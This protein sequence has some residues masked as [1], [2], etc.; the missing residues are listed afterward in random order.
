M[1]RLL[2]TLIA[3][4]FLSSLAIAQIRPYDKRGLNV[5]ENPKVDTSKYNGIKLKVGGAFTQSWQSLQ[6]TNTAAPKIVSGVD[7]NKLVALSPG[8]NTAN[9]NLYLDTQLE[10]GVYLNLT[11]Y[12]SSRHHNET[13]VKG[14][15]IQFDKLPFLHSAFFD[16]LMKYATL[17]VGHME[18]NYGDAH[19]RRSD[20]GNSIYNPFIENYIM[21]G[22]ATEIGAEVD[23]QH[24]GFIGVLGITNGEI[25]GDVA[26][27]APVTGG[28]D[29]KHH[30]AFL[31]KIG[32]DKQLSETVRLR[33]TGSGYYTAGSI[34]NTLYGGDRGGSHYFSVIEN[35]ISTT[36]AFSG[37]FNPGFT[38][39]IGSLMGNVFLKAGGFEWFSTIETTSGRARTET[40]DRKANQ[41]AT[42]AVYRFGGS[43]K[44]WL[45]ARYNTVKSE[46]VGAPDAKLDRVAI[47]GG[48]YVTKNIMAKAEYVNQNYNDFA[49]SDIRN[50]AKFHGIV[51]E[52]VVG[53]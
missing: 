8:F 51:I 15:F 28:S 19:F 16:N 1:K 37:R 43:E 33:I 2:F 20:N 12:L 22:F 23:V 9:A 52:A 38:D 27:A 21:D 35:A 10:D 31:G 4:F 17:K 25:K 36:N 3:A 5:F 46:M 48:W 24:N 41:F 32:F 39:K 45:G 30:P 6:E 18:I 34:S 42:D 50:G 44:F 40:S 47:S 13:W 53:F 29:G 49:T 14:G 26:K 7:Q 11:M